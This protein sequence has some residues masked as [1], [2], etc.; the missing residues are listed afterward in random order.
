MGLPL[1]GGEGTVDEARRALIAKVGEN[2]TVRRFVVVETAGKQVGV[3][4]H[5]N[6]IG[7]VTVLE[8]GDET[9]ARDIAMPRRAA[10][11]RT[12]SKRWWKGVCASSSTR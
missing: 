5:G 6:R 2:I 10:S 3:Y 4:L 12:S 11:P 8:G 7:V 9:L 1:E